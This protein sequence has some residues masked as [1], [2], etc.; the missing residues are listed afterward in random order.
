VNAINLSRID[1]ALRLRDEVEHPRRSCVK[2]G[3]VH[4]QESAV[5][6]RLRDAAQLF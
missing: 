2:I 3:C 1:S 4:C 6:S 5:G